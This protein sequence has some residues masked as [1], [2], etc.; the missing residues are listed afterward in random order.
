MSQFTN[1]LGLRYRYFQKNNFKKGGIFNLTQRRKGAFVALRRTA[2]RLYL[3]PNR[4][5]FA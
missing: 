1:H 5:A 3:A 2:V 4:S